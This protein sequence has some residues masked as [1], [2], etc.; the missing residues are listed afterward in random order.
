MTM[1]RIIT[2]ACFVAALLLCA[3]SDR[4]CHR[5]PTPF[6]MALA[7][8]GLLQFGYAQGAGTGSWTYL[9][10][11]PLFIILLFCWHMGYLGGGDVKLMT[12]MG[13]YLGLAGTVLSF[14]FTALFLSGWC[15]VRM[16]QHKPVSGKPVA[17]VPPLAL[18]CVS[19]LAAQYIVTLT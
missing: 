3:D 9:C 17:L 4:R 14:A 19:A 2:D 7:V 6:L 11:A 8:P 5:I 12:L 16:L 13:F 18:G 1:F 10:A 15:M